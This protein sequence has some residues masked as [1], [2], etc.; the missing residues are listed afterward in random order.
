MAVAANATKELI[1]W[2]T[3]LVC[4]LFYFSYSAAVAVE[5]LLVAVLDAM[6]L[7]YGL[8]FYYSSAADLAAITVVAAATTAVSNPA[9]SFCS[10]GRSF[11]YIHIKQEV[12]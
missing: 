10:N 6:I 7:A 2:E 5:D 11:T 12:V 1:V 3:I 9:S 8:S 4:G